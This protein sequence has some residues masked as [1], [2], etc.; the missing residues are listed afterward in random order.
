MFEGLLRGLSSCRNSVVQTVGTFSDM[1]GGAI[2]RDFVFC[3]VE[4]LSVDVRNGLY[5][6]S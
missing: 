2:F 6:E 5:S 4:A 1:C 3:V